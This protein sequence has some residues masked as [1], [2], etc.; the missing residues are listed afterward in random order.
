MV[1]VCETFQLF[2]FT[3]SHAPVLPAAAQLPADSLWADQDEWNG[4]IMTHQHP[5]FT[6]QMK[7]V[8]T[9]EAGRSHF[10]ARVV[11]QGDP[12]LKVEWL[13]D[14]YPLKMGK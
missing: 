8:Q 1:F 3:F 10:E 4:E 11:P 2:Y 14:G 6:T 13:K 12:H 7:D 9:K 5:K